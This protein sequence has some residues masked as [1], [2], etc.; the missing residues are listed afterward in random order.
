M[1]QTT[2][3]SFSR[4]AMAMGHRSVGAYS[5]DCTKAF[6]C[7]N[8]R[9]L[10]FVGDVTGHDDRAA[11]HA[12]DLGSRL[13]RM[14]EPLSPGRLLASLNTEL[15]ACW[16]SDLFVSAVCLSLDAWTGHGTIAVAGQLPPV[17]RRLSA[18]TPLEVEAG[19]PLGILADQRY[20][21]RD[22]DLDPFDLLVTVTDGITDPLA[23]EPDF[24]G[25]AALAGIVQ[26]AA[27][28][29]DQL[30]AAVLDAAERCHFG[31]DAT[32]L[33]VGRD[34]CGAPR[35]CSVDAEPMR[36]AG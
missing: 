34:P 23:T 24:L 21:E 3:S 4:P 17:V 1:D 18:T 31:D 7:A 10:F 6:S 25:L 35:W 12:V 29:A 33:V 28:S 26:R 32:V 13:V 27:P 22:F 20:V 16:P 11:S 36:L 2:T 9:V 14:A 30:C 8:G 5:G 15:E 19:L